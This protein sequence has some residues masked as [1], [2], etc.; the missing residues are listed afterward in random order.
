MAIFNS[1]VCLPEGT[2]KFGWFISIYFM[3]NPKKWMITRGSPILGHLHME[4]GMENGCF[5]V[6]MHSYSIWNIGHRNRLISR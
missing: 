6:V 3:E 2:P 4:N 1:Y 5:T